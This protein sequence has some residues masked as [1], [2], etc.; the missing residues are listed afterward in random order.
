[1]FECGVVFFGCCFVFFD[2][3]VDVVFDC[4]VCF[5]V[6][7]IVVVR[8][9]WFWGAKRLC[10]MINCSLNVFCIVIVYFCWCF[11]RLVGL[12][13]DY[14][15]YLVDVLVLFVDLCYTVELYVFDFGWIDL[16][17]F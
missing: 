5:F 17:V 11:V 9:G 7:F 3:V 16:I 14:W 8:V 4:V 10:L 13:G 2:C 1:L 12:V 15:Y 6:E